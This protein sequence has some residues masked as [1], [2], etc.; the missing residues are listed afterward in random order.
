VVDFGDDSDHRDVVGTDKI[1]GHR[2]L[3]IGAG[4]N[5]NNQAWGRKQGSSINSPGV[6]IKWSE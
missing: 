3:V 1:R 5:Q 6:S 4:I 2:V